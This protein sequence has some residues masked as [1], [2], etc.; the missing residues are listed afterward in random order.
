[1]KGMDISLRE[2]L[3]GALSEKMKQ[4]GVQ[5]EIHFPSK[6][7]GCVKLGPWKREGR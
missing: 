6:G 5:P 4:P 7:G 1:M 2:S 3:L